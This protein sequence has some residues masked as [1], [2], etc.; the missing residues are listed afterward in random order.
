MTDIMQLLPRDEYNAIVGA[1]SPS[2]GNVF[3]TMADVSGATQNLASVL[4]TGNATG[5]NN[6]LYIDN[7]VKELIG[8]EVNTDMAIISVK[9]MAL[10]PII[11]IELWLIIRAGKSFLPKRR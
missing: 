10:V 6:I 9:W 4:A 11:A 7:T 3:A 8:F 1:A 2:A 5:A